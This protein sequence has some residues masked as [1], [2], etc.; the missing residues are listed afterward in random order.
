M[1]SKIIQLV[2]T[3]LL[4]RLA[5]AILAILV[6]RTDN[7][8]DDEIVETVRKLAEEPSNQDQWNYD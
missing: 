4:V 8:I 3:R 1:I 2:G 6:K 5:L 7:K